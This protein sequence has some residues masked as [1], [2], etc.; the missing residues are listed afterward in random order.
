MRRL[1]FIFIIISYQ[2]FGQATKNLHPT[3]GQLIDLSPE[4]EKQYKKPEGIDLGYYD[5][6]TFPFYDTKVSSS[7]ELDA[8]TISY[9]AENVFDI[10]Y[11]TAWIEGVKGHGIGEHV[12]IELPA[13]LPI[14]SLVFVGGF[15]RSA[16][17]WKEYSRPKT[18]E[19]FV[20]NK[21]F[22]ILNLMDTR[23]EQC[24]KFDKR[25]WSKFSTDIWVIKFKIADI[26]AGDKY[27]RTALTAIYLGG[28]NTDR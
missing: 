22:A 11:K 10:S 5:F 8:D 17:L 20:N 19:M 21:L 3:L 12:I 26:Y 27:D 9:S 6:L 23:Q 7:S 28:C 15:I 24:F 25:D 14:T 13:D 4:G 2:G 16:T 18:L 1:V